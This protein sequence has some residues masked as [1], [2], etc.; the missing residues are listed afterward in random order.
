[1]TKDERQTLYENAEYYG[2]DLQSNMLIEECAE[3]I[4][5]INKHKRAIASGSSTKETIEN[6]IEEMADVELMIM[7]IKHRLGINEKYIE[8]MKGAKI[9]RAK[10]RIG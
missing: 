4:Q 7:Q 6:I 9:R 1:M 5:A 3:L 2:Y 8:E 10:E